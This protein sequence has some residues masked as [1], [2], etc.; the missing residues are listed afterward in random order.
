[1]GRAGYFYTTFS[2]TYAANGS[3]LAADTYQADYATTYLA[4]T[5]AVVRDLQIVLP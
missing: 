1:V 5:N 3:L 4:W 2:F